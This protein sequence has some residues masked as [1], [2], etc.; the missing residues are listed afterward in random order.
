MKNVKDGSLMYTVDPAL[1]KEKYGV[2]LLKMSKSCFK[3][4]PVKEMAEL[5]L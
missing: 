4:F 2:V 3:N 1:Q 5:T